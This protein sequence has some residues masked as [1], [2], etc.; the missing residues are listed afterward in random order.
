M[1]RAK[2]QLVIPARK[3]RNPGGAAPLLKKGGAHGKST[4]ARRRLEKIAL[5]QAQR[6]PGALE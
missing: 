1:K 2:L 5:A 4:G 3:P 6:D